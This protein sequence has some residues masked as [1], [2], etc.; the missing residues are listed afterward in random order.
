MTRTVTVGDD[1]TL[2]APIQVADTNLPARLQDTA[3]S[4]TLAPA[5]APSSSIVY[6]GSGNVTSATENGITTTFTYNADGTVNT[7]TRLGKVRTWTY[8]SNG[9]PTSSTVV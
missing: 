3:L 4:A 8:D 5:F 7:E 1:F 6:D 9:N 2:P